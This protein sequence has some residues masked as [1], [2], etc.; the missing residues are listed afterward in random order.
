[1]IVAGFDI[2]TVS[3]FAVLDGSTVIEALAYR[4][5]GASEP[6]IISAFRYRFRDFLQDHRVQEVAL[7]QPLR[8]DFKVPDRRPGALPGASYTPATMKTFLLLYGLRAHALEVCHSL[9][10]PCREVNQMTWRKSFTGNARA[11]KAQTLALAQRLVPDLT[12]EDAA[13]AIGVAWH[14]NGVLREETILG[15]ASCPQPSRSTI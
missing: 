10:L 7:E 4:A 5:T 1:M 2:A 13:E 9:N 6:A 12:S 8:S 14:L 11:D 3:G 15:K